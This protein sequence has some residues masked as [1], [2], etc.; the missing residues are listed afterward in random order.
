MTVHSIEAADLSSLVGR[1]DV[2]FVD[3]F[4]V[5]HDGHRA[6]PGAVEALARLKA[7]GKTVVLLSNSGRRARPNEER[8]LRLGFRP[9]SWDFFVSSGEVAWRK[10]AGET[11]EPG[12]RRGTK[13]LL[14]SRENDRSAVEELDLRLVEDGAEA[15]IVL[16][17]GSEG[18]RFALDHYRRLLEP[19]ARAGAPLVCTNPDKIMLTATGPTFGAGRIAELYAE[20]GGTVEW[21]G[22]PYPEIYEATLAIVGVTDRSRVVGIGDSIEHDVVGAKNAG[23]AS[24]L[25][26]SG[27]LADLDQAGLE[28]LYRRYGARP[29]HVVTRFAFADG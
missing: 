18:D 19:A 13:C 23:I 10:F 21:I 4:G 16:L 15:E 1:Y 11:A 28:A 2:F 6:Y 26:R 3:Q 25:V 24:V 22:K 7:A 12:L 14:L 9:G 27:I 5:L 20:L 8:L 29:D 17:G